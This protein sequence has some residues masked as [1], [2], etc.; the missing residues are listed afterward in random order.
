MVKSSVGFTRNIP[1]N[2]WKDLLATACK[3]H[4]AKQKDYNPSERNN[5][6]PGKK[7]TFL[8]KF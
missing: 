3:R 2:Q 4:V 8:I 7:G 5:N 6:S 1:F